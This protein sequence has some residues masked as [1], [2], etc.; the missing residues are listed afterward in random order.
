MAN[1]YSSQFKA[2]AVAQ[3]KNQPQR[4]IEQIAS[5]LGI[6][7]SSLAK[8]I[9]AENNS[10]SSARKGRFNDDDDEKRISALEAEVKHLKE[11]NEILKK[12]AAYF[13]KHQK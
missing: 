8:W 7:K 13:A 9:A 4:T 10:H 1:R 6:G 12:A 5:D 3:V 2:A 11:V